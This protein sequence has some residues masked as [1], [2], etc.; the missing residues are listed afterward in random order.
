MGIWEGEISRKSGN[1]PF[2]LEVREEGAERGVP[3]LCAKLAPFDQ[4]LSLPLH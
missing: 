3:Q 1:M 4:V 2:P